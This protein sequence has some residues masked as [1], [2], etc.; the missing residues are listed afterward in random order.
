MGHVQRRGKDRWR[1]RYIGPDGHERNKTFRRKVVADR[2]LAMVETDKLRGEWIDPR[3]SLR[4]SW[5]TGS[6]PPP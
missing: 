2:F 5:S 1:A 4:T 3:S 6:L